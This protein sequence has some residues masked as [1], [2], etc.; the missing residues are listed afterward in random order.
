M[1]VFCVCLFLLTGDKVQDK[2]CV[3]RTM[4]R[5][6][7]LSTKD[8]HSVQTCESSA[9]RAENILDHKPKV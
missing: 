9:E 4:K 5:G 6:Y 3:A 2:N 1:R 7:L 8:L